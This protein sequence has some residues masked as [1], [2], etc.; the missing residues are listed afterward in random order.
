MERRHEHGWAR[1]AREGEYTFP[2]AFLITCLAESVMLL[3]WCV[4]TG[5]PLHHMDDA[6]VATEQQS[7]TALAT[8]GVTEPE[9]LSAPGLSSSPAHS[10]KTP[11]PAILFYLIFLLRALCPGVPILWVPCWPFAEKEGVLS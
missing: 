4:S 8:V 1:M 2:G 7:E 3:P 11:P 5:I 10:L 6:L 9:K